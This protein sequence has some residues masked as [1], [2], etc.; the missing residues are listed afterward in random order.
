MAAMGRRRLVPPEV[1]NLHAGESGLLAVNLIV[2]PFVIEPVTTL[3]FEAPALG[4]PIMRED[5]VTD[6]GFLVGPAQNPP[7]RTPY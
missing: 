3:G 7:R 5:F 4:I 6:T 1:P 2:T